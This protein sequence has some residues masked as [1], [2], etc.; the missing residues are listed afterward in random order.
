MNKCSVAVVIPCYNVR[1][2]IIGVIEKIGLEVKNIYVVDDAS[3]D[4]VGNFVR[5]VCKDPRV[6]II[7]NPKNLGVG[8]AVIAGYKKA[9]ED[10][11]DI[12]VKIDGDGQMDPAMIMNFVMPILLGRADYTKGNRF[13]YLE[14]LNSMPSIRIFGNAIL[15]FFTKISSGY[16]NIFDPTNG[17][18]AIH[19]EIVRH[20]PLEKINPRYF[21]ESD[22]LFRLNILKAVVVDIPMVS[23]YGNEKSNLRI[24][25]IIHEF[26]YFNIKNFL[27]RIFYNYYLRDLSIA[28]IELPVGLLLFGLGGCF[29][30]YHWISSA[31]MGISTPVGTII[32]SA[33][34]LLS[35]LQ[36]ILAFLGSDIASVPKHSL[37]ELGF[38]SSFSW[39]PPQ[40]SAPPPEV[41]TSQRV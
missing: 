11:S 2:H 17:F 37:R 7:F 30:L 9:L 32:L 21:F 1:Q 12:I 20:L 34:F 6:K 38:T 14:G 28:S 19:A 29:G 35:G 25:K 10:R 22:I 18:T 5:M 4:G 3:P 16:W 31:N 26:M 41:E 36:L 39:E 33:T 8:G 15:S 23:H 40:Q 27:K 24:N 13:Y